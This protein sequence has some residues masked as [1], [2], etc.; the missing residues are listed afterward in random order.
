TRTAAIK[1]NSH[2]GTSTITR[3]HSLLTVK[4]SLSPGAWGLEVQTRNICSDGDLSNARGWKQCAT[5]YKQRKSR[6]GILFLP[7]WFKDSV[8]RQRFRDLDNE[9]RWRCRI[10]D[11]LWQLPKLFIGRKRNRVRWWRLR[12]K[13]KNYEFRRHE[14]KNHSVLGKLQVLPDVL[15]TGL[16]HSLP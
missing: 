1:D 6:F 4:K 14:S 11:R 15:L 3:R 2:M 5:S 9:R 10:P 8:L 13:H 7:R 16:A 12:T